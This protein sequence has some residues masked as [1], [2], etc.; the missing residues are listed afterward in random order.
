MCIHNSHPS[1]AEGCPQGHHSPGHPVCLHGSRS[2]R[3]PSQGLLV[4]GATWECGQ[5]AKSNSGTPTPMLI[6]Q[7]SLCNNIPSA[8]GQ[9]GGWAHLPTI[10]PTMPDSSNTDRYLLL[11]E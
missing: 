5:D 3:D 7:L 6:M 1:L 8:K 10:A 4:P 11:S 2:Q 9:P